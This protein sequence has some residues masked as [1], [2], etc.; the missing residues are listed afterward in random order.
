M[1]IGKDIIGKT[2]IPKTIDIEQGKVDLL[3]QVEFYLI[4]KDEK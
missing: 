1:T 3:E 4:N 2:Q